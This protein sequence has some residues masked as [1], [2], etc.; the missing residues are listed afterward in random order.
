[1]TAIDDALE[2]LRSHDLHGQIPYQRV[3]EKHSVVASTLRRR[4]LAKTK[5][6]EVK[7]LRQQLLTP[8]QEAVLIQ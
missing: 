1:M 8:E 6:Q 7:H 5:S 3:A 2:D 4:F